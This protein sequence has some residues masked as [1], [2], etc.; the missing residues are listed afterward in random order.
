MVGEY[1]GKTAIVTGKG[2][3]QGTKRKVIGIGDPENIF[4]SIK[5]AQI[6]MLGVYTQ[7]IQKATWNIQTKQG[8]HNIQNNSRFF[9]RKN[10]IIQN[11]NPKQHLKKYL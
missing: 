7:N 10:Q 9:K 6:D 5:N 4:L 11:F 1:K 2:F 3:T 8:T